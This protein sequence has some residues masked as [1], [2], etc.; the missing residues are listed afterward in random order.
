MARPALTAF[1]REEMR[2]R[3]VDAAL[4]L[5]LEQGFEAVSF[6]ALAEAQGISHTLA[7]RYFENK[8]A[9]F[10]HLRTDAVLRFDTFV[11]AHANP[12]DAP[13]DAVRTLFG[14]YVAYARAHA[15][16][17]VLIFASPQPPPDRYPALLAARQRVFEYAQDRV[18]ACIEAGVL[19]GDAR[20][21]AHAFWVALHGLIGL[22]VA[23][24]LVHGLDLDALG[25]VLLDLLLPSNRAASTRSARAPRHPESLP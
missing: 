4:A 9:L 3:L 25:P 18:A 5:Y 12:A 6:R 22:H 7:Y 16:E 11:R 10:A 19:R 24:Q 2:Q 8:D 14:A 20:A 13:L 1:E 21:M 15:A 17:Y 23:N